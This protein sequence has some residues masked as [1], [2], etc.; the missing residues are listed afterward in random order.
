MAAAKAELPFS[1]ADKMAKALSRAQSKNSD[2]LR[3]QGRESNIGREGPGYRREGN[4]GAR[5]PRR[6]LHGRP[7]HNDYPTR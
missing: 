1:G 6:D 2:M 4:Q 3:M 7:G 5:S